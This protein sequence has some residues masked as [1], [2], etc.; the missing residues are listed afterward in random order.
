[1]RAQV[2]GVLKFKRKRLLE[3]VFGS[4]FENIKRNEPGTSPKDMRCVLA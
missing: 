1:M 2:N 3:T 4:S